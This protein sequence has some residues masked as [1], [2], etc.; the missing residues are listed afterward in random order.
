MRF[1]PRSDPEAWL[2]GESCPF[3][4]HRDMPRCVLTRM[5][6]TARDVFESDAE[7]DE[8]STHDCLGRFPERCP[9]VA[10]LW[11]PPRS[12]TPPQVATVPSTE[13]DVQVVVEHRPSGGCDVLMI[14]TTRMGRFDRMGHDLGMGPDSIAAISAELSMFEMPL[15]PDRAIE[16]MAPGTPYSFVIHVP[17]F[18]DVDVTGVSF[19]ALDH[20]LSLA[21]EAAVRSIEVRPMCIQTPLGTEPSV[22]EYVSAVDASFARVRSAGGLSSCS[23]VWIVIPESTVR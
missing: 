7:R 5:A 10:S 16:T 15:D 8:V 20:A 1:Q 23:F 13:G 11:I 4:F 3:H 17:I 18:D 9:W 12:T 19:S 14:P 2:S 21:S 22:E 6:L